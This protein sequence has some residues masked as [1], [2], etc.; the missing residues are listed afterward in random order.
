MEKPT[1]AITAEPARPDA[2]AEH[3]HFRQMAERIDTVFW[4]RDAP[5]RQ[6]RS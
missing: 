1:T 3:D 4:L 5:G 2:D 6:E